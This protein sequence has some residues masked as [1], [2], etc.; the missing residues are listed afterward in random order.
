[1]KSA[2]QPAAEKPLAILAD[3][4]V[5]ST[6]QGSLTGLRAGARA[7][8]AETAADARGGPDQ[9]LMTLDSIGDAVISVDIEGRVSYMNPVAQRMTGWPLPEALGR[10]LPEVLHVIDATSRQP[11]LNP[12]A[13]AIRDDMPTALGEHSVLVRRDGQESAVEDVATPIHD[14][15]GRVTGAVIVFHDVTA[16]RAMSA[17]MSHLAQHDFLTQLPNRLLLG[18]RLSQAMSAARRH[19]RPLAVLYVDVDH[20]KQVND[21]YGHAVGDQ[22]LQSLAGR[23]RR[24]VRES[25]TISR[26]GG[27]E[28][29]VLLSELNCMAD[30]AL[31]AERIMAALES[32]FHIAGQTLHATVSIGIGVYPDDGTEAESLLRSAD[33]ALLRAKEGGRR[34]YQMAHSQPDESALAGRPATG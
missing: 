30:A 24:C 12:L 8:C 32:P 33:L 4:A 10:P 3:P 27:D 7:P 18:D 11:A 2:K 17:R 34:R 29:V 23:L 20:F 21:S 19:E 9:A 13:Y 16:A 5:T 15:Q 28:F 1:M 25:D 22:L 31:N 6:A 14:Q 26:H